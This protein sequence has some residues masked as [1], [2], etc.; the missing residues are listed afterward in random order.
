[1]PF[2]FQ[3][4]LQEGAST[5]M[6]LIVAF[7]DYIMIIL[8][9]II[10]FVLYIF[11]LVLS[12]SLTDKYI[13][14]AHRLELIWTIIPMGFLLFI[15][16]PSLYLLYITEDSTS[17]VGVLKVIAHQWYWEYEYSLGTNSFSYDSYMS[18][19]P[20]CYR[21]LDVDNR[22]CIPVSSLT[23]ALVTSSDV[24]HSWAV[25][26]LGLKSDATPGRLNFL[27]LN[28]LTTGVFYGQCSE[29]CG[30]NHSFMPIVVEVVHPTDY[31]SFLGSLS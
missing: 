1:M 22:I 23:L 7:H 19:G 24:L 17:P 11:L 8:F 4:G 28:P 2:W 15:A 27:N 3:F 10:A 18:L 29:L 5:I 13:L 31:L 12:T 9:I 30:R 6:E 21:C 25:P 20:N 26:A 14:D 16:F